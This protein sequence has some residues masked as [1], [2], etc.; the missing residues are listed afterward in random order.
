MGSVDIFSALP[1][2]KREEN[3]LVWLK[4]LSNVDIR[5]RHEQNVKQNLENVNINPFWPHYNEGCHMNLQTL[6]RE[7]S[8][9]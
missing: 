5:Q 6:E 7:N 2:Q 9:E 3:K 1:S 4:R 8:I